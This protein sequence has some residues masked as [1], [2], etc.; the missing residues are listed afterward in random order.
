[1]EASTDSEIA[2]LFS[3]FFQT[4]YSPAAWSKSNYPNPLNKANCI[5][6][7]VITESSF[8]RDL[9][10]PTPTYS[11]GPVGLPGCVLKFCTSTI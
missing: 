9:A 3:E 2:D 4:T 7:L 8:L 11:P 5:F 6:T 1:M 10:T